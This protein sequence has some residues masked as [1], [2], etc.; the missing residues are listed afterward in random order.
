[1]HEKREEDMEELNSVPTKP[2]ILAIS[3]DD[4]ELRELSKD[5]RAMGCDGLLAQPWNVQADD[6]LREF[7]YERGNQ[8]E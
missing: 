8:F 1:M 5:L 2:L 4:E 7:L 6:T 3:M